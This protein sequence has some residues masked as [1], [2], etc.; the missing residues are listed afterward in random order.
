VELHPLRLVD[1]LVELVGLDEEVLVRVEE[2]AHPGPQLALHQHL[3]GA[4]GE[5][6][7]LDD[8]ADGA[9]R[10]DVLGGRVVGLGLLLGAQQDGL[11]GGHGLLERGD[12]LLPADEERHHHVREDDDVPQR[13]ERQAAR[14]LPL[15][16]VVTREERHDISFVA[17]DPAAR[18][19]I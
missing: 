7:E 16:A 15:L 14:L 17:G 8:G 3:D 12:R 2:A 9:D 6:E 10:E 13:Q 11:V 4:V 5:L 18:A 19:V 1:H